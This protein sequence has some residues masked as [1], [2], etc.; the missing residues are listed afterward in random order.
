MAERQQHT[1]HNHQPLNEATNQH[2]PNMTQQAQGVKSIG[3][4]NEQP[5][6][7]QGRDGPPVLE[8]HTAGEQEWIE[9][10]RKRPH[11][12]KVNPLASLHKCKEELLAQGRC[13]RCL[14]KG[15]RRFQCVGNL[16]CLKCKKI[17]HTA[18]K[19]TQLLQPHQEPTQ[20]NINAHLPPAPTQL[21]KRHQNTKNTNPYKHPEGE[22]QSEVV[23]QKKETRFVL[24]KSPTPQKKEERVQTPAM[25][26]L[27]NW[28]TMR[29]TDPA[30]LQGNRVEELRVFL[31]P[32]RNLHPSTEFLERSA[33]VMTGPNE[34]DL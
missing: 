27:A 34:N 23:P 30:Y 9:V 19:C 11:K 8:T 10:R 32:R 3:V 20:R 5:Q 29:M 22:T 15:H 17:R 4:I 1:T 31:P 26:P 12:P 7:R 33:I 14:E 28:E 2:G 16:K 21:I 24:V 18:G 6:R 25:D 13:F